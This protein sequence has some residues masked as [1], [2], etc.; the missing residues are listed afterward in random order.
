M[1]NQTKN[2]QNTTLYFF[3]C[4]KCMQVCGMSRKT[5][6]FFQPLRMQRSSTTAGYITAK[7]CHQIMLMSCDTS[8]TAMVM[9][10][11]GSEGNAGVSD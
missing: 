2:N 6:E 8:I 3:I 5:F 4:M 1:T 9:M 11:F 7:F 10:S